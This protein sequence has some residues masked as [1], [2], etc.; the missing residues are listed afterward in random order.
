MTLVEKVA[1]AINQ[2]WDNDHQTCDLPPIEFTD[3]E[4]SALGNA[5]LS[6][7]LSHVRERYSEG[8][9]ALQDHME[10]NHGVSLRASD[11][12]LA[13]KTALAKMLEK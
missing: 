3:G 6:A 12:D 8:S 11:W 4:R 5:A 1:D 2:A 7:I 13:M 10:A 9:Q